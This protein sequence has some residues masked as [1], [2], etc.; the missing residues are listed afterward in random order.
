[1]MEQESFCGIGKIPVLRHV[2]SATEGLKR[3]TVIPRVPRCL[4][5]NGRFRQYTDLVQ[6]E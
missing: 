3:P 6:L 2:A 5:G 4:M 1:M